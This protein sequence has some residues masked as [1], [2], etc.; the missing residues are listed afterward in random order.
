MT[1]KPHVVAIL[2]QLMPSTTL[3]V[4][5][6]LLGLYKT[7]HIT[8][9]IA[10]EGYASARHLDEA[11][12]FVFSRNS[13]PAYRSFL[14]A[15]IACRKPFI[16]DIDDNLFELPAAYRP[17][18]VQDVEARQ[19]LFSE[20]L[21]AAS[22]VQVYSRPMLERVQALNPRA[23]LTDALIDW[24]LIPTSPPRRD[25][26][27]VRVVYATSR[28]Q[29]DELA[30]LFLEDIR[31]ILSLYPHSV[32]LYC[33]GYHP[34]ELRDL[35]TVRFLK[36]ID[37][38]DKFFHRFARAGFDIGLAPLRD[39]IFYRSKTNNK[40][41]EYA[42]CRIAG[43]YS[44]V[45]V[46]GSCVEHERSGLLVANVPGAWFDAIARLIGDQILR[47]R[48]Q[49]QAFSY[50]QR[51]YSVEKT[52]QQ[53]LTRLLQVL[54]SG[55]TDTDGAEHAGSPARTSPAVM[56]SPSLPSRPD[57]R[58]TLPGA[59]RLVVQRLLRF[60]RGVQEGGLKVGSHKIRWTIQT[61]RNVLRLKWLLL[62]AAWR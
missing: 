17:T 32:E 56:L 4:V 7:G 11:D 23:V 35:P 26:E 24:G 50:V 37:N 12:V 62:R 29:H 55:R 3:T 38:Y 45:E 25:P 44:N 18:Q 52:Q 27:R 53:W 34:P 30:G 48:I 14:E 60:V 6:P 43:V 22:L 49:E 10:L 47:A 59:L 39:E 31:K 1:S 40:F 61:F 33:W 21:R 5:K 54:Q 20:Y 57:S 16:Y 42:A 2:P 15:V 51:R 46:Y 41:R 58:G 13:D 28:V 19:E 9:D 36:Y 8:A